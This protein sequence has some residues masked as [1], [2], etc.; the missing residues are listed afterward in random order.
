MIYEFRCK[1]CGKT[2]EVSASIS[3]YEKGL[4]VVCPHCGSTEMSRV[5]SGFMIVSKGGIKGGPCG[6]SAGPGCC[7]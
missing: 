6:P 7:G 1:N 5:F 4:K 2:S 3:E